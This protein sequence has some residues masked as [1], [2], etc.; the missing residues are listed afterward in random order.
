MSK[1]I[2]AAHAWRAAHPSD[3]TNPF[4][5]SKAPWWIAGGWALD[6]FRGTP[7]RPHA[8]LDVGVFRRDV[9]IVLHSISTWQ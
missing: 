6:L 5:S 8:D 4:A 3:A 7:T 2:A 1:D 9:S